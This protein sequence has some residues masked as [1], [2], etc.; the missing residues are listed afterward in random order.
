MKDIEYL[1]T[2]NRTIADWQSSR[3]YYVCENNVPI[4]LRNSSRADYLCWTVKEVGTVLLRADNPGN[5]VGIFIN[6]KGNYLPVK[7]LTEPLVQAKTSNFIR[8]RLF[9]I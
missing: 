7:A 5:I 8:C 6:E 2:V 9:V 1:K 4:I 3:R